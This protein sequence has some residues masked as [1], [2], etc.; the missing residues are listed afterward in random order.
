MPSSTTTTSVSVIGSAVRVVDA[1]GLKIDELA[2]NVASKDDRV[3][4]ALVKAD[5][6]TAEPFL[7]LHYDEWICVLKGK[8]VFETDGNKVEASAG[9]T[10]FIAEGTRFRPSFPVDAEYVPVCLPAFR[11]DRCIREDENVEGEKISDGLKKLHGGAINVVDSANGAKVCSSIEEKP[12]ILY[13]MTTV[14]EWKAAKEAKTAYYPKTYEKD[15]FYTH[16]TGVPSRLMHTANH[17]YLD[18]EGPWTCLEFTRTALKDCGIHVRDEEAMPVGDTQV[19][20]EGM[21]NWICPHIIGGIPIHIVKKE[22]VMKREGDGDSSGKYT[23]IEGL[24]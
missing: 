9:Q 16:A 2:G 22:Y 24:A 3:S 13:H 4:I 8:I 1:P 7:T 21:K 14:A 15:G 12:E 17:Y 20:A 6:G 19:D 5:A 23:G 18:V 10:V 11:P